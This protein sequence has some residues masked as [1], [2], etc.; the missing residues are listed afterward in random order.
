MKNQRDHWND[1]HGQAA[2]A[3]HSQRHTA[4][5]E[6]VHTLLQ[7]HS[8]ILELGC[9]EGNDSVYFAKNGHTITAVDF[10]DVVIARNKARY[11]TDNLQFF[12]QDISK[13][14]P[15]DATTFDA[16][17]ARLSLHY[18]TNAETKKIIA[19]ICRLLKPGG[20]FCFMCKS[21]DDS[22]YN[23]G[24]Q[25]ETDMFELDGHVRHF[26]SEKYARQLL[27]ECFTV[28]EIQLENESI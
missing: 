2:L 21:T 11:E 5:A 4:F 13:A 14:F 23:Q 20:L 12:V 24:K 8:N 22:L 7:G 26:F 6:M 18:F 9:G 10:S 27:A 15:F 28:Q 3:P 1:M 16:V 17:Y 19:E 25:I